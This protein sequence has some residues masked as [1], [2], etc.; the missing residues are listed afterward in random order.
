MA[1][2]KSS[3]ERSRPARAPRTPR[4]TA[5]ETAPQRETVHTLPVL[6]IKNTVLFPYLIMPLSVGR[7]MSVAAIEA[8]A[9]TEE[10]ELLVIT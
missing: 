2:D 3:K 1:E 4:A 5:P 9:N 6:P 7:P 8:A 10:K